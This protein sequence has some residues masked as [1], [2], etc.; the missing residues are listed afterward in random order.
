MIGIIDIN[1]FLFINIFVIYW[2]QK[3]FIDINN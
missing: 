2:Y 3:L 1:I